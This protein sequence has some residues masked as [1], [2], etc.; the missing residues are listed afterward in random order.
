MKNKVYVGNL[1]YSTTKEEL[2]STFSECGNIQD[3][4]LIEDRETGR[5][6]GFAFITFDTDDAASDAIEKNGLTVG[7]RPLRINL[8]EDKPR[9]RF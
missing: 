5:S 7:G 1:S 6:K 3:V 4:R 8:A 9:K 2:E